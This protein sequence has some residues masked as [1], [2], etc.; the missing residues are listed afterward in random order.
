MRLRKFPQILIHHIIVN[1]FS[2]QVG[3]QMLLFNFSQL[4][5]KLKKLPLKGRL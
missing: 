5:A 1:H 2:F 3:H 4:Q